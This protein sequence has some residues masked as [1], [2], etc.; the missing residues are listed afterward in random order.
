MYQSWFHCVKSVWL[1]RIKLSYGR[2]RKYY[3]DGLLSEF[4]VDIILSC[5]GDIQKP[6]YTGLDQG[7][8]HRLQFAVQR[9]TITSMAASTNK[10]ED[11]KW[12]K[13]SFPTMRKK[14]DET[15][16]DFVLNCWDVNGMSFSLKLNHTFDS[17]DT[18][19]VDHKWSHIVLSLWRGAVDGTRK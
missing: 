18:D 14:K 2:E 15:M 16:C 7:N 9:W 5:G 19:I 1:L 17:I 10:G 6:S 12:S 11:I 8:N 3:D 13:T 4:H